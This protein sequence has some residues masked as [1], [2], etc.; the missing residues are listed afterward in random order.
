M[1]EIL[2]RIKSRN[3]CGGIVIDEE[4]EKVISAPP[5]FFYMVLKKWKL[6]DVQRYCA[7]RGWSLSKVPE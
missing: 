7:I 6:K 2:Y 4:T 1:S 3:L 5:I